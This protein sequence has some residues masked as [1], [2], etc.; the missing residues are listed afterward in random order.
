MTSPLVM[1]SYSW[2]DAE[3]AELLHEELAFRGAEVAH[4]RCSFPTGSRLAG[5][6]RDAALN[7]DGYVVYFTA[8]SLYEDRPDG[9]RPVIDDEFLPV[10]DR[11]ASN[12]PPTL[13]PLVHGLGDPRAEA[14]ERVRRATGR[15]ISSIW[16][17]VTLDQNTDRITQPEA[18][19]VARLMTSEVFGRLG[20]D[21]DRSESIELSL[22][23]RGNGQVPATV[24]VDGTRALGGTTPRPGGEQDWERFS[25]GLRDLESTLAASTRNRN[26]RVL[27]RTHLTGS[28]AFG[29]TFHQAAGWDLTI[30]GRHGDATLHSTS[31]D[32][33]ITID[34]D[35]GSRGQDVSVEIDLL[36]VGVSSLSGPV[37]ANAPDAVATRLLA[38]RGPTGDLTPE[39][40]GGAAQIISTEIRA[41]IHDRRPTNVY[42][43]CAAPVEVAALIGHRLT[44]LHT[45]VHLHE[46]DG[47]QYRPS[48]RLAC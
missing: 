31:D 33:G 2:A 26:L 29:R 14:P 1:V 39:Q 36:G 17:P 35:I 30:A 46:R 32:H 15:D 37:L 44:S 10:M 25:H 48:L 24:A 9:P 34:T 27:A 45:T 42:V 28:I 8:A 6:M 7:C 4:D 20:D 47:N 38:R 3:A 11:L 5:A 12:C 40:A 13:I 19:Q 22:V 16:M 21:L 41:L 18:A 43:F 23:T